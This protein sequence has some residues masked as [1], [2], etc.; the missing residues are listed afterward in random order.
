M[1]GIALLGK[2]RETAATCIG[3]AAGLAQMSRGSRD[4]PPPPPPPSS[5]PLPPPPREPMRIIERTRP[6]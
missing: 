4:A 5:L 2:E 6:K 3:I 1:A